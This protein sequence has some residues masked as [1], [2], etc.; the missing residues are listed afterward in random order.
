MQNVLL[1][2]DHGVLAYAMQSTSTF[3]SAAYA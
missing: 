2:A 1:P 3:N